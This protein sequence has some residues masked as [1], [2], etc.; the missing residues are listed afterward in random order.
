MIA[1][2]A[3]FTMFAAANFWASC[4]DLAPG[5][6]AS[7][8]ALMNTVGSIFWRGFFHHHR[9]GRGPLRLESCAGRGGVAH[10]GLRCTLHPGE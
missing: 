5:H 4:I 2:A 9:V 3:G 7:L 10:A 8:S 1:L 6:S